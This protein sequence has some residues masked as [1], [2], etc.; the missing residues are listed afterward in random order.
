MAMNQV[1]KAYFLKQLRKQ[2]ELGTLSL[3]TDFPNSN[4]YPTW[5][6]SLYNKDWVVYAKPPFGGPKNVL[7]YL[8][9]YSHKIAIA[10]R[11]IINITEDKVIFNY[12][13][14]ADGARK[15]VMSLNGRVFLQRF[16]LHI[17]P[18]R[19]RKIRHFGF[20]S[21]SVK[22]KSLD[23]AK[24]ALLNKSHNPL[25]KAKCRAFAEFRL[26][27]NQTDTCPECQQGRMIIVETL[28]PNKDPPI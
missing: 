18:D 5:K 4:N 9:R 1:Y 2:L 25:T 23:L 21:N 24:Q 14:Y 15:K 10:N 13:D 12:K 16:C 22:K 6:E 7:N 19:F 8:A 11:R 17:V 20:L 27:G 28:P 3:P 26:F